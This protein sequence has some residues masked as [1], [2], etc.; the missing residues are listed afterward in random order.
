MAGSAVDIYLIGTGGP[1]LTPDRSGA[2]TLIRAGGELLL[3]DAGRNALEG[4]YRAGLPPQ[5]VTKLFLTHLHND[6]IEGIPPLWITPWFLLGRQQPL[7][8]WGPPGTRAMVAGMREMFAHDLAQRAN[9]KLKR[10]YL[11]IDVRE[12]APGSVYR[13]GLIAVHAISVEHHDG[14]PAFAFRVEAEGRTILL[15]G[16]TTLTDSL[17]AAGAGADVIIANVAAGT[18]QLEASG[19]IEPILAK[20]LRP[21]QAARLFSQARPRLA[22]YSHIVKKNLP[23]R[24]GDAVILR[25]TQRAGF[26]GRLLMGAD[27]MKIEVGDRIE[28]LAPP[29]KSKLPELDGAG[30]I[31]QAFLRRSDRAPPDPRHRS[32]GNRGPRADT[33]ASCDPGRA[34]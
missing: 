1:E 13:S 16:D 2:A 28:I 17:I 7:T 27:G 23:G 6:H 31:F 14:N 30:A 34:G 29:A 11:D 18:A 20:L 12:I 32:T 22:V 8:I 10:E 24:A 4:I 25:R 19:A 21:E 26:N 33:S 5:G 3:F 15:T 9:E